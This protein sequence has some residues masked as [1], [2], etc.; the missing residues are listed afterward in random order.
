[1]ECFDPGRP[2]PREIARRVTE[3]VHRQGVLDRESPLHLD[4]LVDPSV[5][6]SEVGGEQVVAEQVDHLRRMDRQP[7]V[8]VRVLSVAGRIAVARG[9]FTLLSGDDPEPFMVVTDD[10]S[11]GLS[12][13]DGPSVVAEHHDMWRNIWSVSDALA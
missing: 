3:R 1:M 2:T 5:F 4:A 12:Y 8:S 13:R 9:P 10:L 7:N 11:T 6:T